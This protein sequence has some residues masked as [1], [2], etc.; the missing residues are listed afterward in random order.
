[1][2]ER[3]HRIGSCAA[4]EQIAAADTWSVAIGRPT[5]AIL[6]GASLAENRGRS[7]VKS[8]GRREGS[9]MDEHGARTALASQ[10]GRA[11]FSCVRHSGE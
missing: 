10:R 8:E 6:T 2:I 5:G 7:T 9:V 1:M 3:R 4:C 11:V